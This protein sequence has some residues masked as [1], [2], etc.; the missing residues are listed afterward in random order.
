V[1]G[2]GNGDLTFATGWTQFRG[3]AYS[4]TTDD[5]EPGAVAPIDEV[6]PAV[7]VYLDAGAARGALDQLHSSLT[8]CASLHDSAYDFAS[9]TPDPSTLR[10]NSPG[11]SHQYRV[12]S[13]VGDVGRLGHLG[14]LSR[15]PPRTR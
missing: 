6:N 2:G 14:R 11:W 1:P 8:A 13:S 12:K 10:L 15:A 9:D 5:L 3:I 7:A 4:G